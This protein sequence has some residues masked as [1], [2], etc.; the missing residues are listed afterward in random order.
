[1]HQ[2]KYSWVKINTIQEEYASYGR[3]NI[4]EISTCSLIYQGPC[5]DFLCDKT[6]RQ[7]QS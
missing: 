1:M 7:V 6:L 5:G 4:T 2:G 3:N